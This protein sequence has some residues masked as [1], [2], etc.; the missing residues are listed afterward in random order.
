MSSLD[1]DICIDANMAV[2]LK[3]KTGFENNVDPD[4]IA[5]GEPFH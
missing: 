1:L 4:K 5:R 3:S 2:S